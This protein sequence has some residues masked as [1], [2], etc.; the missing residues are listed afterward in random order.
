[1]F[2]VFV[3]LDLFYLPRYYM[4]MNYEYNYIYLEV[5]ILPFN[6]TWEF[7]A[8]KNMLD[9]SFHSDATFF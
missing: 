6:I 4:T 5:K 1:L 3:T 9:P 7:S 8:L 2:I